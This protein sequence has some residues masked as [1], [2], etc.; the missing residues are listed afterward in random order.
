MPPTSLGLDFPTP[1]DARRAYDLP[2]A[3]GNVLR[4]FGILPWDS[5][6]G[7]LIDRWGVC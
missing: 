2:A 1:E 5:G 6:S 3:G 4:P 7:D